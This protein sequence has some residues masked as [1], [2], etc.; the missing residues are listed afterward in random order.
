MSMLD[1]FGN[2]IDELEIIVREIA[3]EITTSTFVERL[4][5]E[6]VWAKTG[7]R[8]R[9]VG[10][11]IKEL[12]EYLF[13]MRPENVPTFQRLSLDI[14]ERLAVFEETLSEGKE[15]AA[16]DSRASVEEL[17]QALVKITD[18]IA[19]CR[20]VQLSPSEVI[21]SILMLRETQDEGTPLMTQGKLQYLGELV[22]G[23]QGSQR[24]LLETT[25]KIEKQLEDIRSEY[26]RLLFSLRKKDD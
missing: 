12:K 11:L 22:K 15:G 7:D 1:R 4:S 18:F 8:V 10:E 19:L 24:E 3:I 23:V 21:K 14:R 9:L 2:R 26:D 5:P 17:R 16:I 13:I 6:E 20:D 25:T